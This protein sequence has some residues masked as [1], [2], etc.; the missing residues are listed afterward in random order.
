LCTSSLLLHHYPALFLSSVPLPALLLRSPRLGEGLRSLL[1]SSATPCT[2]LRSTDPF[3]K[4]LINPSYFTDSKGSALASLREAIKLCRDLVTK[5]GLAEL[6]EEEVHPGKAVQSAADL[7]AC[8]KKSV[9]SGNAVV[10][11][12]RW[13]PGGSS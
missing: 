2:A 7:P 13:V 10:G 1:L 11:T 5:P 12:C 8:I 3:D 6:V 9:C 4:P